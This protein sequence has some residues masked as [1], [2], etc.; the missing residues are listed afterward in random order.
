MP[1]QKERSESVR[2]KFSVMQ[3][4]IRGRRVV[5]IDDS[6]VR[7]TTIK[8][9]VKMIRKAGAREVHVRVTCPQITSPCFYGIDM[10]TY[11]E[12]IANQKTL[13]EIK[14]YIEADSL[15]YLSI[16]GLKK[17]IGLPLCTGCLDSMY[18]SSQAKL[19]QLKNGTHAI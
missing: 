15:G 18:P 12:L 11:E 3:A 17:A 8:E 13:D 10:S 7:G 1:T 6:I 2:L 19:V 9:I 4:V 14:D 16:D 5:I